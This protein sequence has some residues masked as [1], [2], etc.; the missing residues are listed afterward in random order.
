MWV[1]A[2]P[3]RALAQGRPALVHWLASFSKFLENFRVEQSRA[4]PHARTACL[5]ADG[6]ITSSTACS[7]P[8]SASASPARTSAPDT[9]TT[10]VAAMN[11]P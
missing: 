3:T 11:N 7:R 10:T 6:A 1:L 5:L 2:S 9:P 8:A 4:G